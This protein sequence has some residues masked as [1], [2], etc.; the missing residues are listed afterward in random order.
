ML[1]RDEKLLYPPGFP[2]MQEIGSFGCRRGPS[3]HRAL[4]MI[5][6][7]LSR[8]WRQAPSC[9]TIRNANFRVSSAQVSLMNS[10]SRPQVG[11]FRCSGRS[12]WSNLPDA[13]QL[14]AASL[15][16]HG[17]RVVRFGLHRPIFLPFGQG[18][19]SPITRSWPGYAEHSPLRS[20]SKLIQEP[21]LKCEASWQ[22]GSLLQR[23]SL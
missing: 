3:F 23:L 22:A 18:A 10:L 1:R 14:K 13:N 8:L 5:H 6:L 4:T 12:R 11:R 15:A 2:I 9:S 16:C 17:R 20:S 21:P 7:C 19:P